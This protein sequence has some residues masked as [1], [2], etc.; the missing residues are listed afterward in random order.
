M[1]EW[2]LAEAVIYAVNEEAAREKLKK[3]ILV[4]VKVGELQQIDLDIFKFAME[5]VL[6]L[7][8]LPLDM[9]KI[10]IETDESTLRCQVCRHMWNFR[11]DADKLPEVE[12]EA[13]HFIPEIAH[14]Y[15]RC[16]RCG[17]PDFAIAEEGRGVR[18]DYI[19]GER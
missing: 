7:S 10:A 19:E 6:P 17:S 4:K 1:H 13:I 9:G 3:I 15:I 11:E 2:A 16:P 18:I 8:D 14:I 12:S 5:S